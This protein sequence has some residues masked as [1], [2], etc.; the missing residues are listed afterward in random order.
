MSNL[1]RV[2]CGLVG[3]A[4]IIWA[5]LPG[6]VFYPGGLGLGSP[7]KKTTPRWFGRLWFVAVGLGFIYIAFI[8]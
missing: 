8:K 7:E 3:V 6:G 5:F 1:E 2:I 4:A